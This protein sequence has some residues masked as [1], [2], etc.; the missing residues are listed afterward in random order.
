MVIFHMCTYK[1]YLNKIVYISKDVF[2]MIKSCR[3]NLD[4]WLYIINAM[5]MKNQPNGH[6][7]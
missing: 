2:C 5:N 3:L 6:K 1:K 4:L 7:K